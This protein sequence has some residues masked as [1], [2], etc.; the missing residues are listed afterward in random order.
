MLALGVCAALLVPATAASAATRSNGFERLPSGAPYTRAEWA[1]DG[2]SATWDQGMGSRAVVDGSVARSG[3][4]SLRVLYPK[5][6]IG[7]A[8]SGAQAPFALEPAREYWVRQWVRF[9]PDFSWGTTEYGGKI[10]IGLGGG[11]AC[12]GGQA[13][14]GT[15]GF[16]SRFTWRTGGR[17][18]L[19]VYHMGK[20]GQYGD[21]I[22]LRLD[23]APVHYPLGR[24]VELKQ[25]VRVNTVANG[26]ANPDG[27]VEVWF[28]GRKAGERA[29]LR[30]VTNADLVDRAYFSSFFGGATESFAPQR[31]SWIWYDDVRVS[32]TPL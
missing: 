20:E 18:S 28:D 15:N 9:S 7:P 32:T 12:S 6:K 10:G 22:D 4:K 21:A 26:V 19:Y 1:A 27:A 14:D 23:G 25:R 31:D 30:F 11:K 3:G 5:G 17:A 29:G 13:C 8:D 16:T 24:W 2:W